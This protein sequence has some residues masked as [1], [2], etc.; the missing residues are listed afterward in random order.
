MYREIPTNNICHGRLSPIGSMSALEARWRVLE[1]VADGPFFLSWSWIGA[2]LRVLPDHNS[3][4]LYEC[5]DPATA[6]PVAL[7]IVSK[8]HITRKWLIR[9]SVLTLNEIS[10]TGF[11][12][13]IEYNGLLART[14]FATAAWAQLIHVLQYQ[15]DDWDELKL[16]NIPEA[17]I[18]QLPTDPQLRFIADECHPTWIASLRDVISVDDILKRLSRNR[19]GQLRRS[20]KE[21]TALG[22]LEI[23][24]AASTDEAL[25]FFNDMGVLHTERWNTVGKRGAYASP[26]WVRFHH[27]LIE[28]AFNRGEIQLLRIRCGSRNIGFI[29]NFLW[30]GS[31][32]MLQ[33]GF[34]N[35]TSNIL[36]PGYVSHLL[37]ME[38]NAKRGEANYDFMMGDSEYK[39]VL[40]TAS[41]PMMSVRLQKRRLKFSIEDV[42]TGL[43]R[44]LLKRNCD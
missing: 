42:I 35:E 14:E 24:M 1:A 38:F 2:W 15:L 6:Q 21:Y 39:R 26:V 17:T 44:R 12:L 32:L 22:A 33:S 9:S 11:N 31:V 27:D 16:T 20:I 7:A 23:E 10:D 29:Y 43:Y 5:I 8:E 40:G 41:Q 25:R 19:R 36:R 18:Q 30:R 37:A 34:V 4:Y 28:S 3:L 13:C